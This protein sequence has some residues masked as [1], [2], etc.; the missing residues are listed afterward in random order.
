MEIVD[1]LYPLYGEEAGGGM[2]GGKQGPIEAG[3]SAYLVENYPLLDYI[4]R[5]EVIAD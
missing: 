1:K 3:G 4:I 5:A 2:R